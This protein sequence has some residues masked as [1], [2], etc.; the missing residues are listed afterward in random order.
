MK[1]IKKTL[2]FL[3][4]LLLGMFLGHMVGVHGKKC[5]WIKSK[6]PFANNVVEGKKTGIHL[7]HHFVNEE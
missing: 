6:C 7:Y 4:V 3:L 5:P 2:C 1:W